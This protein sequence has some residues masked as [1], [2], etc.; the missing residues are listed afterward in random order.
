M[1]LP[2]AR[3][4]AV[5]AAAR[6]WMAADPHVQ[7]PATG[8]YR[9]ESIYLDT[10]HF[11]CFRPRGPVALPKY[12]IRRYGA[13]CEHVFLEEKVRRGLSV[14]KRRV[15]STQ[16]ALE[17]LV[18]GVP[19]QRPDVA[20]YLERMRMLDL[21]ATLLLVY[22]RRALVGAQGERFTVD[23][24]LRASPLADGR[25]DFA[26]ESPARSLGAECVVEIKFHGAPSPLVQRLFELV[27][28]DPTPYSKYRHG[29]QVL[30]IAPAR[31]RSP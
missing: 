2:A 20:W 21:R 29:V 30:G 13:C 4:L 5:F 17:D 3:A 24:R 16:A 15:A 9:V 25:P 31:D 23:E 7:D 10:P 8:G 11:D 14:W 12:R 28:Q 19:A 18:A 26:P 27:Q 6:D 22:E 1:T